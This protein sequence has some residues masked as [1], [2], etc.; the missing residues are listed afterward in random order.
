[1]NAGTILLLL[2]GAIAA[3]L[4][5]SKPNTPMGIVVN[6]SGGYVRVPIVCGPGEVLGSG[7][8]GPMC[9]PVG[10]MPPGAIS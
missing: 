7:F 1:M 10:S 4:L 9:M 3:Y 6:P 2:G 8:A 5:L